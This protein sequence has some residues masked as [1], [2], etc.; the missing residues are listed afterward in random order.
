MKDKHGHMVSMPG[1]VGEITLRGDFDLILTALDNG[2]GASTG[3]GYGYLAEQKRYP[4]SN[5]EWT[6]L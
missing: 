5:M 3:M 4:T 1:H 6:V 2:L